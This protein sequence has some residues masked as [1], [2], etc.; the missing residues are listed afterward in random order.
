MNNILQIIVPIIARI[1]PTGVK[2]RLY[3]LGPFSQAIRKFLNR[4]SPVG[5]SVVA[6]AAGGNKGMRMELDLQSEKDYWLGTYELDLQNGLKQQV[7]T[8]WVAYDV[9]ANIGYFTLLFSKM[10]GETGMVFSFEPLPTNL[11]RLQRNLSLNNLP[12]FVKIIPCAVIDQTKQTQFLI[13]SSGAM[14]KVNGSAGREKKDLYRESI[15]VAGISLDDFIYKESN[16]IP[17]VIKMDIEGGEVLALRGMTRLLQEAKPL[18]F[19]ELHG[20]LAAEVAWKTLE[21][22]GYQ[23]FTITAGSPSITSFEKLNWKSY[24]LAMP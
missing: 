11:E 22:E 21:T 10:V 1:L 8:G 24:L 6:V 4:I 18:F 23:F 9:G 2:K 5:K 16:P 12:S 13:G 14:G 7:R 19:L 17:Q 15:N 20:K 3:Q